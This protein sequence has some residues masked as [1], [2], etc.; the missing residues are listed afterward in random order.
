MRVLGV[1]QQVRI[2]VVFLVKLSDDPSQSDVPDDKKEPIADN[3]FS[4]ASESDPVFQVF[5]HVSEGSPVG[6]VLLEI[7]Q[8]PLVLHSVHKVVHVV[9]YERVQV[10]VYRGC[11]LHRET[12][13][14]LRQPN[15]LLFTIIAVHL[16]SYSDR[17]LIN[18]LILSVTCLCECLDHHFIQLLGVH[19]FKDLVFHMASRFPQTRRNVHLAH[20]VPVKAHARH[21]EVLAQ[22]V[23]H[24]LPHLRQLLLRSLQVSEALKE[25]S[26]LRCF[27]SQFIDDDAARVRVFLRKVIVFISQMQSLDLESESFEQVLLLVTHSRLA[28]FFVAFS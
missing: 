3:Q 15:P 11:Y 7:F 4:L 27:Q 6:S 5:G 12:A 25:N 18:E 20:A 9:Q 19:R 21:V 17:R 14:R 16:R 28:A 8:K 23:L 24:I 10:H 1:K 26:G 2:R 22:L 13:H